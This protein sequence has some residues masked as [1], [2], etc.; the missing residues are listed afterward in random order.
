VA[1]LKF[2]NCKHFNK[3]KVKHSAG[4]I[5]DGQL[6]IYSDSKDFINIL[7]NN[8][9]ES[10][11]KKSHVTRFVNFLTGE[12]KNK[13]EPN[14]N[15]HLLC[16]EESVAFGDNG[17]FYWGHEVAD[18]VAI[19]TWQKECILTGVA[20]RREIVSGYGSSNL[21]INVYAVKEDNTEVLLLN[22][23]S[24][25]NS[26]YFGTVDAEYIKIKGLKI[27]CQLTYSRDVVINVPGLLTV[28][29]F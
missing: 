3:Y 18:P 23:S 19:F 5:T 21:E 17:L 6:V 14:K 29:H 11:V 25:V 1:E 24:A 26:E 15:S 13:T 28:K 27:T 10:V 16:I 22:N 2:I 20:L 8:I 12:T 4:N 9:N 7:Y